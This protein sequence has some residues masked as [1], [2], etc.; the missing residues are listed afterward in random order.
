MSEAEVRDTVRETPSREE[1]RYGTEPVV[2]EEATTP[3]TTE[4]VTA[5]PVTAAPVTAAP[6]G[7]PIGTKRV[8]RSIVWSPSQVVLVAAGVLFIVFGLV[9]MI[10]GGLGG[11]LTRPYVQVFG[12]AQTPLLGLIEVAAGAVLLLVGLVPGARAL[13][14]LLGALVAVA[15][16]LVLGNLSWINRNLTTDES[17]G[18]IPVIAGAVVVIVLGVVPS[19]RSHKVVYES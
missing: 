5:A 18:W 15:G 7:A 12:Y 3:V 1:V 13:G 17:F 11:D 6:I 16:G 2:T 10:K 19:T 8:E 14:M 9:A 4:P